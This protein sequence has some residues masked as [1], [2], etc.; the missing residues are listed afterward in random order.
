MTLI[1]VLAV[2]SLTLSGGMEGVKF[3]LLPDFQ[4]AAEAG[5]G[6]VI[7]AAM[8]QAFFTLSLGQQPATQNQ[9]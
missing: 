1:I 8:N 6:N 5:L 3:Y 2:H 4:R 7:T 9:P